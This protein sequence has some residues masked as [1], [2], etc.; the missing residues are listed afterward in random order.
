MTNAFATS[1]I[2]VLYTGNILVDALRFDASAFCPPAIFIPR[3]L[4]MTFVIELLTR[5]FPSP[6]CSLHQF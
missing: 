4:Q 5:G 1:F 6:V 3:V 2:I